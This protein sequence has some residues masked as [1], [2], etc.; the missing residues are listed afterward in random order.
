MALDTNH[1]AQGAAT[2]PVLVTGAAGFIGARVVERLLERGAGPVRCLTRPGSRA[3]EKMPGN[4]A[5]EVVTGNLLSRADCERITRRVSVVYHLA[6]GKGTKSYPDAFANSVVTTRN[7]MDACGAAGT[8]RRFVNVSSFSVYSNRGNPRRRVL[9]ET[10]PMEPRPA[11]R[12]AYTYAKAKQDEMATALGRAFGIP[13]VFVRPGYV[14]GPG[15]GAAISGRIGLGSFGLF[16]HLGGSNPV[17]LTYVDNCAD[18]IVLAGLAPGVEGEIFN[19]VDDELPSSR[20]FLRLYKRHARRFRSLYLPHAASYA[21]C[22]LWEW[23]ARRSEGQ[24]PPVYNRALWHA[25]WKKTRYTNAK[26]KRLLGWQPLI[27]TEEGL[28]RWFDACR[29]EMASA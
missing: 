18:A 3:L 1:Q 11:R 10:C 17:P 24:I 25:F 22:A 12:D 8:V 7:L 15:G 20:R 9:D 21:L 14:Y 2:G 27:P 26:A 4:D 29:E 5:V 28:R 23:Y 6:A 16:L 13:V 19:I